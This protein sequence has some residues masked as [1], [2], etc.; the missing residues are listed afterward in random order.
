MS[1]SL[2]PRILI[3]KL[4]AAATLLFGLLLCVPARATEPTR[5]LFLGI[6]REGK[7]VADLD[8]AVRQRLSALDM[9]LTAPGQAADPT[10][11]DAAAVAALGRQREEPLVLAGQIRTS[12]NGCLALLWLYTQ[13]AQQVITQELLCRRE[14]SD[15][16]LAANLAE[17][18]GNLAAQGQAE[19]AQPEPAPSPGAGVPVDPSGS[20]TKADRGGQPLTP[21]RAVEP[22]GSFTRTRR[23][24]IA[25]SGLAFAGLLA[26]TLSLAL[27][28]GRTKCA[29][30]VSC[31]Q[32]LSSL[33]PQLSTSEAMSPAATGYLG[34][35]DTHKEQ[36]VL[37]VFAG[38]AG[39]GFLLT[40]FV[41]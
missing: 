27:L 24:L 6:T 35:Q 36:A 26:S 4:F 38:L 23:L 34:R 2:R 37:G 19:L 21:A 15:A 3:P 28:N 11:D 5:L 17:L 39:A 41:P 7:R 20:P 22:S 31:D 25:G 40:V 9:Q 13:T 18:A 16:V 1:T 29:D 12:K 32:E 14:W 33:K 8:A 10:C 30:P